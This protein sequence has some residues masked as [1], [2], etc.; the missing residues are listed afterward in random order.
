MTTDVQEKK[1]VR[2]GDYVVTGKI[3]QGGIAEIF[4]ARQ[5]SLDRDVA[6]K[7][8]FPKFTSDPDIVRRFERESLVVGRLNHPNIVHVIDRGTAGG[9][10]FF[11]ME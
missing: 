11:V 8:L 2:I 10:Y 1:E 4:R 3:G 5:E 6:I 9:R 7:I